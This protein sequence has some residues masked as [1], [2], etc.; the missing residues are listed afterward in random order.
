MLQLAYSFFEVVQGLRHGMITPE[1]L[2]VEIVMRNGQKIAL[3]NRSLLALRRAGMEPTIVIDKT[4]ITEAERFLNQ[5]LRGSSPS[6]V[7]RIRGGSQGTSFIGQPK[8]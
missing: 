5:H 2:P 4:G 3:N 1:T 8:K 7:I 6:D